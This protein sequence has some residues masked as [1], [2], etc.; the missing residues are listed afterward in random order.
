MADPETNR[1]KRRELAEENVIY[2]Q[3]LAEEYRENAAFAEKQVEAW[4][5]R[6]KGVRR[7]R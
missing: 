1:R 7:V 5:A 3:A 2:W 4:Q 6:A